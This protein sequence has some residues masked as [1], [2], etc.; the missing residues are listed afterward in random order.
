MSIRMSQLKDYYIPVYQ[1]RYA[2]SLIVKYPDTATIKE[3]SRFQKNTLT[4]DMIFIKEYA[5]ASDK[6]VGVLYRELKN[7]YRSCVGSL[8]YLLSSR[9]DLCI[10]VHK[11]AKFS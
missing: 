1:D 4:H 2:T 9:S 10:A 6:Q 8:I 7:Y 3:N 11:M 5:S